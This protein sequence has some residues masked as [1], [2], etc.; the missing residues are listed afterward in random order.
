MKPLDASQIADRLSRCRSPEDF[1]EK[2]RSCNSQRQAIRD[3]IFAIVPQI[4]GTAPPERAKAETESPAA[5][6]LLDD[7]VKTLRDETEFLDNLERRIYEAREAARLDQLR[8]TF[9]RALRE[10]PKAN[11]RL[12]HAIRALDTILQEHRATVE[13][14]ARFGE[15]EKPFPFTDDQLADL[16][17]LREKLWTVRTVATLLPPEDWQQYIKSWALTY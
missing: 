6:R 9:P 17:E 2:V 3:R 4:G 11:N 13:V 15:I 16:I 1:D 7:E 8:E 5:I 12:H 10:L 14:I